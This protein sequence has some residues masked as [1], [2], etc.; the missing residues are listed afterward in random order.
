MTFRKISKP[1]HLMR[2][3]A[4]GKDPSKVEAGANST[5]NIVKNVGAQASTP[6]LV[7]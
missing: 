2:E 4:K 5:W 3:K 1:K 7:Y 6:V